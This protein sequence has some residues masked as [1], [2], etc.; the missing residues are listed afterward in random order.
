MLRLSKLTDY[1]IL[2]MSH[3]AQGDGAAQKASEIAAQVGVAQPTVQKILK[4][5]AKGGYLASQRGAKGGYYLAIPAQGISLTDLI[6]TLEGPLA[7]TECGYSPGSCRQEHSCTARNHWLQINQTI[8]HT[9]AG[10][11]LAQMS[12]SG[13]PNRGRIGTK[14]KAKAS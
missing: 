7:L 8:R 10:V 5:L 11:S 2:I 1:A 9:L 12:T 6:E 4:A 13:Q 14:T 3:M